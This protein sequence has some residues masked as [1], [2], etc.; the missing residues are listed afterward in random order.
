MSNKLNKQ[1]YDASH[2][3]SDGAIE[4]EIHQMLSQGQ[5]EE[6]I[7]QQDN[8]WPILYHFS[9]VRQ[10]IVRWLDLPKSADV[11]EIGSGMGAITKAL[12]AKAG[13]VTCVELSLL[14]SQINELRNQ[15]FAN[16]EIIVANL[17][18]IPFTRQYDVVTL[19]GVL[20]YSGRY[21]DG[22]NP[23][24]DFLEKAASLVKPGG[25]LIIAIENRLGLKYF[26]GAV[27]DHYGQ[28]FVGLNHYPD[29]LGIRTF[30][31]PELESLLAEAQLPAYDLYLPF[32]DYKFPTTIVAADAADFYREALADEANF[33]AYAQ[34]LFD[35]RQVNADLISQHTFKE[36]ANS[37]LIVA[38]VPA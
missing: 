34:T 17:N 25:Q 19:I 13:H 23:Y 36:F 30:S 33:G 4:L 27:E 22:P 31:L 1:W 32:P 20:E 10:N 3:Y 5:S 29:D 2:V 6:Q 18:D 26:A 12:C 24:K 15:A 14:R 7:L 8:R 11:L 38:R 28:P 9:P 21:T 16:L 37:F 35:Q